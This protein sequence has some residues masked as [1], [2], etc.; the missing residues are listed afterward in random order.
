MS[1]LGPDESTIRA[2]WRWLAHGAHGVS[3]V[4]VI[5]PAGGIIGIGFFDDE[6]A[7]VRECVRTNAAGNVYVGIQPRPRRLFDAA[8][9][10]VRPLK[11]GA[12]RKDIE[13]ITATVI[14]LDP[15]RPKDTASTDAELALAMAAAN[16]AIAW[17]ESEG[18]VRPRLMMSGNGAQL[19]FALPPTALEGERRERLQAGLKA[20]ETKVRERAQTDAVHVDSIHDVARIIKV[21]GTV[22]HKGDGKGDRPHRVSAAL[23]GFD[24]VEDDKLLAR[25]DVEPEPTLPVA[26][27][28]VSLPIVGNVAAPGTTK[29]KRTPEGE[30]DWEHPV[31]M[32]GPIQRLWDHGA[33]DRSVAIF[34]MVRFFAHKGLG[35][36]EITELVL[37]Y[38]RRGLGKLR[39]RDGV[40]YVAKAHE[41]VLATARA[42][43]SI[44]P[45]CHSLQ[46]I[47]FCKVNVEPTARCDLYDVVFD[48]EKAI[49]AVP[50]DTPARELEYRLKPILDAIAHRDPSVQ[51]KY[52]GAVEKRF[53]LKAK[54]LRK[55]VA[56]AA[57][58]PAREDG[59]GTDPESS[60]EDMEGA[61]FEDAS[62]YYCMTARGE[63]KVISSFTIE[64]TMRVLTEDGEMI[65]GDAL[66]DKHG[67]V[68]GLRLPLTAFHSKRDLI[69]QLPSADLQWTGS[70]N[71]VQGLLRVLARREIPRRPGSNMLGDYK[72]GEHHVWLGPNCA[73]GKDG[74]MEP[75]PVMYV[76]SGASLDKR[77]AYVKVDEDTFLEVAA[78]VFRCLPQVNRPEVMLPV[79]GWFFATPMKPRFMERVGTFPTLFVWGTQGSGKS[80]LCIDIMWP[81]F[82]IRDAEPYSATE[83]E[84]ALLKLLTSTRSVPVF[85]DEYK[86]YD[87]QRQRLNTLHRYLRRLY[88]GETEERGRPDLKV[89]SYHL[90]APVCVAGET[91]PTE[92]ALLERI[93]TANPDKTTLAQ[94]P[95]ARAAYKELR[96]VDLVLF[97]PA[98]HP[99]LPRARLR[100]RPRG[101][102]RRGQGAPRRPQ[103]AR[104]HRREPHGHAARRASLRGVRQA[105]RLRAPRR[106]R[107]RGRRQRDP[108]GRAGD[109]S[110]REE[111]PRPLP[112]DARRDGR[113]GRPQAQGPLRVRGRA[114]RRP[115]R[116][117]LR[118]LPRALQAHRLRGRD[119]GPEGAAPP[120]HREQE[121]GRLRHRRERARHLRQRE[122]PRV[123][124]RPQQD[125]GRHRR[126]L[127]DARGGS[128][129][130]FR[131]NF[132][133]R[134]GRD[135]S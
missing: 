98:L 95:T 119:G 97:A 84:F 132:K 117:R 115:P 104:A 82:G 130:G 23:S 31:E 47:G 67:K 127:P 35:L 121:A 64:P 38:D 34:D 14:D 102:A 72:K 16:E 27:P 83:T 39:G 52:L 111:R 49:E 133:G 50:A 56:K 94:N 129:S 96:S 48:I 28:R 125:Q 77:I 87:M 19:W 33:E 37:E 2:T 124:R 53:G 62:C 55:A 100:R 126:R 32:C 135:D 41:K 26:A 15:V 3:E 46:K 58:T 88:R 54:D 1:A 6:E 120:R 36:D 40:R 63:S 116:E 103:G 122:A 21:I 112:R 44:A 110:R 80:S 42:D 5:R 17:C 43:G 7:F 13:V 74:F 101:R 51:S 66:T 12:G 81:L 114:P 85:I 9:N 11:T 60:D 24:R 29:A 105:L 20:F 73:I 25:L 10:V 90:Q 69:R 123:P 18:L 93:V 61:I 59:E 86:P 134:Y 68:P 128:S 113:A 4:R 109:R 8:P 108:R 92:A 91:R 57:T 118:R 75:S 131:D 99:V 107:R 71:N 76:P 22:S 106:A 79:I 89:N 65:F 45:P 70:D 30:Y 78:T